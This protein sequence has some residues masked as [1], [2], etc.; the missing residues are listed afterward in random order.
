MKRFSQMAL[1]AVISLSATI[2]AFAAEGAT[3][4]RPIYVGLT[5][6]FAASPNWNAN[7]TLSVSAPVG[8]TP[9]ILMTDY[10]PTLGSGHLNLGHIFDV[11]P[12]SITPSLGY[13]FFGAGALGATTPAGGFEVGPEVGLGATMQLLPW[14]NIWAGAA[15]APFMANPAGGGPGSYVDFNAAL[16]A[17]HE[18][19]SLSLGYGGLMFNGSQAGNPSAS[20]SMGGPKIGLLTR[21]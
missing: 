11:G 10:T 15:Y 9:W 6:W 5:T 21:F 20:L 7:Y 19:V 14:L 13:R 12:V 1:A 4:E 17:S 8:N 18:R 16:Q 3:P 2:P